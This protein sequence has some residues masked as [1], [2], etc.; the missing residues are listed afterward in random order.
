MARLLDLP[1]EMILEIFDY[2]QQTDTKPIKLTFYMVGAAY[3]YVTQHSPLERVKHLHSLLLASRHLNSLLTPIFYRDICVRDHLRIGEKIPIEQLKWT[4]KK[5]PSLQEHIVSAILPFGRSWDQCWI[6][7]IFQ[8]FWFTNI[9][10]LTLYKFNDWKAM[11]FENNSHVGTSPVQCLRLFWCG[12]H[13]EALAAVL[14]WP[15]ALKVLHYEAWE[16]E[17][18]DHFEDRP[19]KPWTC[20]AFVRTL[21][22][23]RRTL[24]EL[25]M[26]RPWID[27]EGMFNG[28]RIDLSEFT[29]LQTLRIS[30]VFLCG[31]DDPSG[32]WKNLPHNLEVLE[33]FYDDYDLAEFLSEESDDESYDPFLLDLIRNKRAHL[34]HLRTVTIHSL[35]DV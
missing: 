10:T 33:V 15:A 21:Q 1:N 28:P 4:L 2:L 19:C 8:V 26:T 18:E 32:V 24:E 25:T 27:H 14:S 9:Q 11:G 6:R 16:G 20:A 29:A 12:A 34:P 35:E 31:W 5:D 3:R 22:P 13:E 23:Q 17:W 30:H 7:D